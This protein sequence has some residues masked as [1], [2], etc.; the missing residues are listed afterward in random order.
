MVI[1]STNNRGGVCGSWS[2]K[3]LYVKTLFSVNY[4]HQLGCKPS[5]SSN[6]K[7]SDLIQQGIFHVYWSLLDS[8]LVKSHS[9]V[10]WIKQLPSWLEPWVSKTKKKF[11]FIVK[12]ENASARTSIRVIWQHKRMKIE[13]NLTVILEFR[14]RN[15]W[16]TVL[17]KP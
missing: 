5:C 2:L 1:Q 12:F 14:V 3:S 15:V 9:R 7:L 17:R 8:L 11:W 13:S 16:L 10:E 6:F 4:L